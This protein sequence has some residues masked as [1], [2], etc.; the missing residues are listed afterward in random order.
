MGLF[1]FVG[2]IGKKLFGAKETKEDA[3]AKIK[4]EIETGNLGIT[5]LQVGFQDSTYSLYSNCPSARPCRRRSCR[6]ER[7]G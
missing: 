6:R 4:A 7:Q 2:N 1:D 5:D 3:A